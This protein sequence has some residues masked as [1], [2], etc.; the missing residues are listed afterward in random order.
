MLRR[1]AAAIAG[2]S[3]DA[4]AGRANAQ[5]NG[6]RVSGEDFLAGLLIGN[7]GAKN[8]AGNRGNRAIEPENEAR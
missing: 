4:A 6:E 8:R 3:A 5:I 7:F 2:V 1:S